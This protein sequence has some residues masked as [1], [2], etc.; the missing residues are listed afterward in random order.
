MG[1]ALKDLTGK[2]KRPVRSV[3][4]CLDGELWARHDELTAKLDELRAQNPGRM[5]QA[6]GAG[7]SALLQRG[8]CDFVVKAENAEAAGASAVII[9]NEGQ[10]GR[11]EVLSGTLGNTADVSLGDIFR[12]AGP[13]TLTMLVVLGLLM[14]FPQISL[15]L[16]K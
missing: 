1:V 5:G 7:G 13:F 3:S 4:V 16:L 6:S 9:F 10:P 12:G 14:V 8:T 2:V 15:V 11:T